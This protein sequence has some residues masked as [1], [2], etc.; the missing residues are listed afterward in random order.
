MTLIRIILWIIVSPFKLAYWMWQHKMISLVTTGLVAIGFIALSMNQ[1][2]IGQLIGPDETIVGMFDYNDDVSVTTNSKMN[3]MSVFLS[4]SLS[5]T[6]V[7]QG[8][9]YSPERLPNAVINIG[10]SNRM[11]FGFTNEY[12]QLVRVEAREIILQDPMTETILDNGNY[13]N[14]TAKVLGTESKTYDAGH[15]IAD[16][17]GG[18]ANAYNITPQ[19]RILN[20]H[21]NQAYMER[22]IRDA[23]GCSNF[24]GVITYPNTVSQI[25][26]HYSFTYTINEM[27]IIDEFDNINPEEISDHDVDLEIIRLDKSKEEVVIKNKGKEAINLYGYKL[28]ST[29]GQQSFIFSAYMLEANDTV[30]V[31]G[32]GG[33]GEIEGWKTTVWS[34]SSPDSA[35]LYS[36]L[37]DLLYT[38]AD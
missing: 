35:E 7:I 21:G 9:D 20:R 27:T 33:S 24:I 4:D 19:D 38:Y 15:V 22:T 5:V 17:L 3:D 12:G 18:V 10:F 28:V 23:G 32:Q 11:Y 8:D 25:P 14:A 30:T 34:N 13:Y 31:Y 26:I 1:G 37:G 36:P 16:S 2:F 29:K 6:D